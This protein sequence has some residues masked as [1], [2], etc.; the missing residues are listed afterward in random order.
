MLVRNRRG[1]SWTG[2]RLVLAAD[3]VNDS[4]QIQCVL[5]CMNCNLFQ[6]QWCMALRFV[7][8]RELHY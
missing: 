8:C 6:A 2:F 7:H 5:I 4:K 1:W 3:F